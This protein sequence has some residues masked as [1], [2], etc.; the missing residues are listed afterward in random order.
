[1][2]NQFVLC[3]KFVVLSVSTSNSNLLE[4]RNCFWYWACKINRILI[5]FS[6]Y[7]QSWNI[8]QLVAM[9]CI[10]FQ[11]IY[12]Y[13]NKFK[14]VCGDVFTFFMVAI[15]SDIIKNYVWVLSNK[16]FGPYSK[17]LVTLT[18]PL[19]VLSKSIIV[20]I[21]SILPS[22]FRRFTILITSNISIEKINYYSR[23]LY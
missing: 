19:F 23:K 6:N 8:S 20:E 12:N 10:C 15:F 18:T 9:Q 13:V 11:M 2:T 22:H 1:M 14:K 4:S 17:P 5:S 3:N 16:L 21:K 7:S